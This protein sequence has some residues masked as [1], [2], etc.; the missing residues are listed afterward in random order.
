MINNKFKRLMFIT[1]F[2]FFFVLCKST[3]V[4]SSEVFT[5]NKEHKI[6]KKKQSDIELCSLP[7]SM[8]IN[9]KESQQETT[10]VA[11]EIE[12]NN[13][14][15]SEVESESETQSQTDVYKVSDSEKHLLAVIVM[16]EAEGE[17]FEGKVA[18]AQVVLYRSIKNNCSISQIVYEPNQFSSVGTYRMTLEPNEDCYLAVQQVLNG[19][20]ILSET[21]EYFYNPDAGYSSWFENRLTY[22][23]TIGK[24]RFFSE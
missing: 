1:L 7:V 8:E 10:T 3:L 15:E 16:A 4:K 19:Q 14:S 23:G 24:H 11:I 22:V 2:P 21:L 17:P 13:T 18:V 5:E 9:I 6:A 20:W 12:N